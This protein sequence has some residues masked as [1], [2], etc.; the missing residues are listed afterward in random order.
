MG[1]CIQLAVTP[2]STAA[3]LT[4]QWTELLSLECENGYT[5]FPVD[6]ELIDAR[7]NKSACPTNDGEG[8]LLLTPAFR[9][10][11]RS[12]SSTMHLAYIET[13]YF[14]G[15]GGQGAMVCRN[16]KEILSPC[17]KNADVINTALRMIGVKRR[18]LDDEFHILGLQHFRS[19][20]DLLDKISKS[21]R[22]G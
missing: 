15:Q 1:H 11:L 22:D 7:I 16:G 18:S 12:L 20:E 13:D 10:V 2:S 19:N 8:F 4:R 9:D 5:L 6:A 21:Q 14:G 17:W 3:D